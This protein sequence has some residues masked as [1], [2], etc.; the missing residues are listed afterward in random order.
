MASASGDDHRLGAPGEGM[1]RRRPSRQLEDSYDLAGLQ[2]VTALCALA[3]VLESHA[4]AAASCIAAAGPDGAQRL[5]WPMTCLPMWA[6]SA[7]LSRSA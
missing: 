2:D 6:A 3:E 1:H 4:A 5:P 7:Q